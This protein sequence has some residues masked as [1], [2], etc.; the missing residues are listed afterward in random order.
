[1]KNFFGHYCLELPSLIAFERFLR[2]AA[3]I[4][5]GDELQVAALL[6]SLNATFVYEGMLATKSKKTTK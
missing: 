6:F 5:G 2:T 3:S 1:M 4:R